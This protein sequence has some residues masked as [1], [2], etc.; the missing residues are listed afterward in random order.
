MSVAPPNTQAIR[1]VNINGSTSTS[2]HPN[3]VVYVDVY[4]DPIT[5][6]KFVLWK[7]IR[8]A[9]RNALH[10][11]YKARVLPFMKGADFNTLQLFR[12]A[13][14]PGEVLDIVVG[15]LQDTTPWQQQPSTLRQI[16]QQAA[17]LPKHNPF[18]TMRPI[19]PTQPS[20]S[21]QN[22]RILPAG[23]D[24]AR[25]SN[26]SRQPDD[27]A[28]RARN[29][30]L[31]NQYAS[32]A[33]VKALECYLKAVRKGHAHAQVSVGD[34]FS[35]G[36]G[37]SK[38]SSVAMGWYFKAAFQGDTT[39]L[40]KVETLTLSQLR[41]MAPP[42]AP[43]DN[44]PDNQRHSSNATDIQPP[45]GNTEL[46][47]ASS[48]LKDVDQ[49]LLDAG[50]G[51]RFSQVAAGDMYRDGKGVPQ[52][53]Q[54]AMDW[55]LKAAKQGDPAGQRGI[56][57]LHYYGHG[58]PRDYS[59]AMDWLLKAVDQG[60]ALAQF[61]IGTLYKLGQ[62][63]PQD[64]EQAMYWYRK[65]ADQDSALAQFSIGTLY[66]NGQGVTQDYE[67]AMDWY[68]KA[69]NQGNAPAQYCIGALYR[70]GQGVPQD[71]E[72]AMSWYRKAA[73]QGHAESQHSV[74]VLYFYSRGVAKDDTQAMEWILKAAK[75]GIAISQEGIGN[76]Y[77]SGLVVPRDYTKA[78]EWYQMAA[79]Q[80]YASAKTALENIR[81]NRHIVG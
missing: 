40:R 59:A 80:G 12:I 4:T 28:S 76:F 73:D 67:Q 46:R 26:S 1:S 21:L 43:I 63:V 79:D 61:D 18:S 5:Q 69:A 20:S 22:A 11:R 77:R 6:D 17:R 55:Y 51:N 15:N 71:Y 29:K 24:S 75:Q 34:L 32:E 8:V 50:L 47:I 49:I 7:D 37:V 23:N 3:E 72:Q 30:K 81:K 56:G 78:A 38:D 66:L 52:D 68:L 62:D 10:I 58:V 65:A 31:A 36:Q 48:T 74:G 60:N 70:L 64:Y 16:E 13:V 44:T 33:M 57:G 2:P 53:Y 19:S 14:I 35:E 25:R 39:A 9:F 42:N 54:A 27:A 45:N 41:Q